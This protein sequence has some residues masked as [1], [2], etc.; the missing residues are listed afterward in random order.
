MEIVA[1]VLKL[2]KIARDLV[3]HRM[4]IEIVVRARIENAA[5]R[6]EIEQIVALRIV[7]RVDHLSTGIVVRIIL[8]QDETI[9]ELKDRVRWIA[10]I[11]LQ[12]AA[13]ADRNL[14]VIVDR[15]AFLRDAKAIDLKVH[16]G[17]IATIE[18]RIVIQGG[19]ISIYRAGH[20]EDVMIADRDNFTARITDLLSPVTAQNTEAPTDIAGHVDRNMELAVIALA[21]R[22]GRAAITTLP[23]PIGIDLHSAV[24]EA[25]VARIEVAMFE[26]SVDHAAEN[27]AATWLIMD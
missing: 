1:D 14:V 22:A 19:D 20:S 26:D 4:R 24:I 6:T 17:W 13:P 23:V 21:V 10:T 18:L 15:E 16:A 2:G 8:L 9:V 5:L 11:A 25:R 27:T 12:I 7:V 3:S